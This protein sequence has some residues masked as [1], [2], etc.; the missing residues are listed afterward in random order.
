MTGPP[1]LWRSGDPIAGTSPFA[2][3]GQHHQP[4]G[5]I[6]RRIGNVYLVLRAVFFAFSLSRAGRTRPSL[7]LALP[8]ADLFE[9]RV[10]QLFSL[11]DND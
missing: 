2:E 9:C 7:Y 10:E 6:G 8:L 3:P 4:F 11:E 5:R 1:L